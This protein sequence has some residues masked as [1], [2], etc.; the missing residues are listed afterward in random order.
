M[1]GI[2]LMRRWLACL[3][4]LLLCLS[5]AA[6]LSEQSIRELGQFI[7][8]DGVVYWVGK[9]FAHVV[10]LLDQNSIHIHSKIKGVPVSISYRQ[11]VFLPKTARELVIESLDEDSTPHISIRDWPNLE[12]LVFGGGD[13][14]ISQLILANCPEL[15]E[16]LFPKNIEIGGYGFLE[17]T[18]RQLKSLRTFTFPRCG[19]YYDLWINE[20]D[21]LETL[22]LDSESSMPYDFG[23]ISSA[24]QLSKMVLWGD[25]DEVSLQG[26][27]LYGM[28]YDDEPALMLYPSGLTS[29]EFIIRDGTRT[30]AY[31][32]FGSAPNLRKLH[33][34]ASLESIDGM[35][36]PVNLESI[37]VDSGN[38]FYKSVDGVLFSKDG[39][40]LFILPNGK[41]EEYQIPEGVETLNAFRNGKNQRLRKLTFPEG[42]QNL[43]SY[44]LDVY[45]ALEEVL[46]PASVQ[47]IASDAFAGLPNLRRI[48]VSQENTVYRSINGVLFTKDGKELVCLP[49]AY[50][51]E[52]TVPE[53]TERIG[54]Y[55][56]GNESNLERL[57]LPKSL[58]VFDVYS[59]SRYA[60]LREI[61]VAQ[62]NPQYSSVEG[63][64]YDENATTLLAYPAGH[65]LICEIPPGTESI[66]PYA[67]ALNES[68]QTV[69]FPSSVKSIEEYAFLACDAV[70]EITL[71]MGL[72][73]MEQGVFNECPAL[74]SIALPKGL[75]P[76]DE[77]V[78]RDNYDLDQIWLPPDAPF[79]QGDSMDWIPTWVTFIVDK[80]SQAHMLME[81][82]G[83]SYR[84]KEDALYQKNAV[85]QD[86]V[87]DSGTKDEQIVVREAI[88]G[89]S[90]A[91]SSYPAGT[92]AKVVGIAEGC[93]RVVV[94]DI[95]GY[96]DKGTLVLLPEPDSRNTFDTG[97]MLAKSTIF[98]YASRVAPKLGSL[99]KGD[100]I[101]L[102]ALEGVW[103]KITKGKVEGYIPAQ[104]VLPI[105]S[106]NDEGYYGEY[107]MVICP[108]EVETAALR[109]IPDDDASTMK[110]LYSGTILAGI[111]EGKGWFFVET[112]DGYQ[113]FIRSENFKMID[114]IYGND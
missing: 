63:I 89:T 32:A 43:E 42:Y 47:T 107:G 112:V 93:Y 87:L 51:P 99:K 100:I 35:G 18:L 60:H 91:V 46:L 114:P 75:E 105:R 95:Q 2:V 26:G 83:C 97:K 71:P 101:T 88:D 12:R 106:A 69:K 54:E 45:Q 84:L 86:A 23:G 8:E 104:C 38:P 4:V 50:G 90:A 1:K 19:G 96:V 9:K 92:G 53:G 22:I 39:K 94:G 29:P 28:P 76:I 48:H 3:V 62:G 79:L 52:Y 49:S 40:K 20:C 113:G 58:Q 111:Y 13:L 78:L 108:S 80:G 30:I 36:N 27:A 11:N 73:R 31:Y 33:F 85:L 66:G 103:Y 109:V 37:E 70:S 16:V 15:T 81:K 102:A 41:W 5:A 25:D 21:A 82:Y 64:L 72:K 14:Y 55:A 68:I 65:G 77:S 10:T 24:P 17:V 57:L 110:Q 6:A 59:P 44:Q 61:Q 98:A 56:L 74:R 7:Q 34:P 67:F